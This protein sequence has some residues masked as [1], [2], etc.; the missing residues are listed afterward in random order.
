MLV[1]LSGGVDSAVA[2]ALLLAEGHEVHAVT[3]KIWDGEPVAAPTRSACY[4]ADEGEDLALAAQV[5][6]Q[7]GIK[8]T[9]I[10]LA[11]EYR[12]TVLA[13]F[14]AEYRAGRTPNPCMRCNQTMKFGALLA[15]AR[16]SGIEFDYFAT[17]HYARVAHN[18]ASG[19]YELRRGDSA[20]DQ[21][22]FLALLTQE[23][24]AQ[25]RFP[26]G[27]MA[28]AEVRRR[29][30]A[31]KLT[32]H[33]RAES[34]DF[35]AGDIRDLLDDPGAGPILDAAGQRIGTHH[36][37]SGYTIGQRKGLKISAAQPL[38]VTAIDAARNAVCVGSED[39]LYAAAMTVHDSNWVSRA[40]PTAPF[41]AVVQIRYRHPGVAARVIPSADASLRVEFAQAQR[42]VTPGQF[43]VFY[44]GDMVIGGGIIAAAEK[45]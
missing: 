34:Q 15:A 36:G 28:K 23:Q 13:Y 31:L 11:A 41:D 5:A 6:A 25:V 37:I 30:L 21:S 14:A 43:A 32:V 16:R 44:D 27:E 1:G 2:A 3:M 19:R 9:V 10:D 39:A 26:L 33:D 45:S 38:Y 12:A 20:K 42:A 4:G 35:Y 24:L 8:H 29:A 22:Y 18:P 40:R 7:L 17:G